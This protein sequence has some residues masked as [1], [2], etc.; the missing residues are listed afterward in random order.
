MPLLPHTCVLANCGSPA[1]PRL[2]KGRPD[3]H[4]SSLFSHVPSP[5]YSPGISRLFFVPSSMRMRGPPGLG[6]M[7]SKG[8][9]HNPPLEKCTEPILKWV[10]LAAVA[11]QADSAIRMASCVESLASGG[12]PEMFT[13]PSGLPVRSRLDCTQMTMAVSVR[14]TSS[15][16]DSKRGSR[17]TQP[18][19]SRNGKSAPREGLVTPQPNRS[20]IEPATGAHSKTLAGHRRY[21]LSLPLRVSLREGRR[22]F[23]EGAAPVRR[24]APSAPFAEMLRMHSA[25]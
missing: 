22:P 9:H 17:M 11:R 2:G 14:A 20:P 7:F 3:Q 5:C 23:L 12:R 6:G 4:N 24:S 25:V 21:I 10:G 16:R 18:S 15:K 1:A 19:V 8:I 13:S